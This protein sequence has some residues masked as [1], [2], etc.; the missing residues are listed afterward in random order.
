MNHRIEQA[1]AVGPVTA[2]IFDFIFI[3]Y[4]PQWLNLVCFTTNEPAR[5]VI[6]R[7]KPGL[8]TNDT[9]KKNLVKQTTAKG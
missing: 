9:Y 4:G 8:K 3:F 6:Y 2:L 1:V 7:H 5:N